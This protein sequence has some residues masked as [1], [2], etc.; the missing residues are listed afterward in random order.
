[1]VK[2]LIGFMLMHILNFVVALA[3]TGV[4]F[5]FLTQYG[6][7]GA[8]VQYEGL[9]ILF[10]VLPIVIIALTVSLA[11]LQ[12]AGFH[13]WKAWERR[14]WEKMLWS[15]IGALMALVLPLSL[16]TIYG[17]SS[18]LWTW[19]WFEPA[20]MALM[21]LFWSLLMV[22]AL[23]WQSENRTRKKKL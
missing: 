8:A 4:A 7:F 2:K 5:G 11:C 17:Q 12:L 23:I 13:L 19:G 9:F 22:L 18:E 14:N 21:M 3:I 10:I 20:V 16:I 1:M 6:D 15:V